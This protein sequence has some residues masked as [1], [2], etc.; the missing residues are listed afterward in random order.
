MLQLQLGTLIATV[1][2][3]F[4]VQAAPFRTMSDDYLG[5]TASFSLL[6]MFLCSIR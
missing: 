5:A 6:I 4:Q 3:F 1:L 2:L